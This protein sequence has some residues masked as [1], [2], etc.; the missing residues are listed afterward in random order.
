MVSFFI[1]IKN[2]IF[3]IKKRLFPTEIDLEIMRWFNDKGDETLRLNYDNLNKTSLVFDLGGYKGQWTSDIYSKYQCRIFIF[4]PVAAFAKLIDERFKLN[5]DIKVFNFGLGS[6]NEVLSI[7]INS[8]ASSV[9]MH[10]DDH[11]QE[12]IYIKD[13]QSFLEQN[14]IDT[15]D[16]IKI[17]IEGAEFD[18]MDYILDNNL[19]S[20][21]KTIQI[22]F[23]NFFADADVRRDTIIKK[24]KKTHQQTWC[25]KFVWECGVLK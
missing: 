8:D 16:L 15:I 20:R 25:Y 13:F 17:N 18:L 7:N 6:K 2:K 10:S 24:L 4:E 23:H 3:Q 5:E 9:L 12:K 19:I 11:N 14:N 22:Q 1:K 21:I